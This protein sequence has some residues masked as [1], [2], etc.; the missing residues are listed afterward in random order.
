[1]RDVGLFIAS[2]HS[3]TR[4]F[5]GHWIDLEHH[6]L[7]IPRLGGERVQQFAKADKFS[8]DQ[9]KTSHLRSTTPLIRHQRRCH[10]FGALLIPE[11]TPDVD[12]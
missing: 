3:G 1:V 2:R 4:P 12:E 9:E 7:E 8:G 6:V 11:I 5:F 10:K